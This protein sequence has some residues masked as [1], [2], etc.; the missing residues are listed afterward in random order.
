MAKIRDGPPVTNHS[1]VNDAKNVAVVKLTYA[2]SA[3]TQIVRR[4]LNHNRF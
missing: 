2:I 1:E 4:W 3:P